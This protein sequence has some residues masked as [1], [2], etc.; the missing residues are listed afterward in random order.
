MYVAVGGLLGGVLPA[1]LG[2][3]TRSRDYPLTLFDGP[4]PVLVPLCVTACC[5]LA[6]RTA[7]RAA[8]L[9]GTPPSAR[10]RSPRALW[11]LS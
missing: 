2:L 4:W 8:L 9:P 1:G 7:P 10:T 3:A 11:P 5:E 6:R